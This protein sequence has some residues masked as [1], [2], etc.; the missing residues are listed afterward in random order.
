MKKIS[1]KSLLMPSFK[2]LVAI[3]FD[4]IL[5]IQAMQN[6][7]TV[8]MVDG[9]KTLVSISFGKLFE[10][11]KGLGFSQC[12]KSYAVNRKYVKRYHLSR[13]VELTQGIFVPVA[14]RRKV[15]FLE[16]VQSY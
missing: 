8:Y 6:Y 14:R 2:S 9:E 12:H 4:K 7:S 5:Y 16:D 11:I 3:E 13:E 10:Q 15:K 1:K